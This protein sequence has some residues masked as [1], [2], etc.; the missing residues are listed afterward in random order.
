[1]Y[2][3]HIEARVIDGD[4]GVDAGHVVGGVETTNRDGVLI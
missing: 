1:M 4:N 2:N 3:S